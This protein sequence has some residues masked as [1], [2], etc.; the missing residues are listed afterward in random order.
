MNA[1]I[2]EEDPEMTTKDEYESLKICISNYD[3][4]QNEKG[5]SDHKKTSLV[6]F[7]CFIRENQKTSKSSNIPTKS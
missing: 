5:L 3:L 7:H 6:E 1:T 4:K 2:L